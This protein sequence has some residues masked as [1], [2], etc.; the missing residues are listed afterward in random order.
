LDPSDPE[1]WRRFYKWKYG[2]RMEADEEKRETAWRTAEKERREAA[3]LE[4]KQRRKLR[5]TT[6]VKLATDLEEKKRKG[7]HSSID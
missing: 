6:R 1:S 3:S 4:R 5:K 7:N 2:Q